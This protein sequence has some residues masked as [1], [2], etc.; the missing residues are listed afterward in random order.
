MSKKFTAEMVKHETGSVVRSY[1]AKREEVLDKIREW[2]ARW[3]AG[4]G[5]MI[6]EADE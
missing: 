2:M 4:H 1:T 6:S 5:I 3:P